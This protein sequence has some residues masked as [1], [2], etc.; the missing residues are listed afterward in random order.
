[1]NRLPRNYKKKIRETI[2]YEKRTPGHHVQMDVKF[3]S[4]KDS[5]GR[6]LKRFQYTAIDDATKDPR[7]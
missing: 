4:F 1:M 3:L 7:S 5:K 2:L 6:K